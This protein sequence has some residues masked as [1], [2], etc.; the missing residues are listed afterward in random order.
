[1]EVALLTQEDCG[2]CHQA[3]EVLERLSTEYG[4]SVR[5]LDLASPEGQSLAE[6][7]AVPF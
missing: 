6:G 4:F 3:E 2:F 7:G 1:M 5:T